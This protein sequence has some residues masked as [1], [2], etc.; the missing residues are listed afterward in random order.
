MPSSSALSL[1]LLLGAPPYQALLIARGLARAQD[2]DAQHTN[3]REQLEPNTL[4]RCTD[5]FH[6]Y[7]AACRATCMLGR[8]SVQAPEP[9]SKNG[10]R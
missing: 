8:S 2:D 6:R 5:H 4:A 9:K 3:A 10:S 1:A 7:L